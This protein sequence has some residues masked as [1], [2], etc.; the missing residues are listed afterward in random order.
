MQDLK[1]C[2]H[3]DGA[4]TI[5]FGDDEDWDWTEC[6]KCEA[7]GQLCANCGDHANGCECETPTRW[8]YANVPGPE[9]DRLVGAQTREEFAALCDGPIAEEWAAYLAHLEDLWDDRC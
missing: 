3:C 5:E 2:D 6:P 4:K 7:T 8:L 1:P 9:W